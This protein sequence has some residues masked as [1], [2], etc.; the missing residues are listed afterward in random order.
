MGIIFSLLGW[1][2]HAYVLIIMIRFLAHA[3]AVSYNNQV[4]ELLYTL[5]RSWSIPLRNLFPVIHRIDTGLLFVAF[6]LLSLKASFP[7]FLVAI[8]G[9]SEFVFSSKIFLMAIVEQVSIVVDIFFFAII[10]N[11]IATF[12]APG[13]MHPA[14]QLVSYLTEPLLAPV[15]RFLPPISGFD[16]SPFPVILGL[17]AIEMIIASLLL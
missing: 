7:Y 10:I 16:L 9:L 6:L 3:F 11:I 1:I 4:M 15:R 17:K 12:L 8:S 2:I 14:L 13:L 5:T